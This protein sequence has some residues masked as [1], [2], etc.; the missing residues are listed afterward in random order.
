VQWN[1]PTG[2]WELDDDGLQLDYSA[3]VVQGGFAIP[4]R[5]VIA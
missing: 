4:L 2:L 1:A 5:Q 3:P